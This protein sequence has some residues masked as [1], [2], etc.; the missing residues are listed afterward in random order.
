[1]HRWSKTDSITV[2]EITETSEIEV[3]KA[4]KELG[5]STSSGMDGLDSISLKVLAPLIYRPLNHIIHLSM[6]SGIFAAKWK[7]ANIVPVYK[8]KD[9]PRKN[10]TSY[11]PI[12][13]LP[14]ISKITE[15]IISKQLMKYMTESLQL[16]TNQHAYRSNHNT[17]S[18][19]CKLADSLYESTDDNMI[20]IILAVDQSAAFNTVDHKIL[21]QKLS[22]YNCSEQ[23]ISWF[24]SYLQYRTQTVYIRNKLS[25][26][27]SIE[28]GVPQ[29]SILGPLLYIIYTNKFS[30]IMTTENNCNHESQDQ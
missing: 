9:K 26:M 22:K 20:S 11:R 8:G 15:I 6:R 29:G 21:L 14:V 28:C 10:P 27:K 12:S 1:M 25:N 19:I 2:F 7:I 24:R 16:N 23:T 18:A 4:L 30:D 5:N 3:L 13:L 17:T